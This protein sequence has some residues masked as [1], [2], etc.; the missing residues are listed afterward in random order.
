MH[1]LSVVLLSLTSLSSYAQAASVKDAGSIIN[2]ANEIPYT[3]EVKPQFNVTGF[4]P[5]QPKKKSEDEEVEI[6]FS[7]DEMENNDAQRGR[8]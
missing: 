3:A 7:A 2:K 4:M 8:L 1:K 5:A 6:Y